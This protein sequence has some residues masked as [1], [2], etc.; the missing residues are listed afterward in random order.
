MQPLQ[1]CI[2]RTIC[3]GQEILDYLILSF[4]FSFL[5]FNTHYIRFLILVTNGALS[6]IYKIVLPCTS[7]IFNFGLYNI[8]QYELKGFFHYHILS[9]QVTH[10][11]I[12]H[13]FIVVTL[14][15]HI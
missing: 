8:L 2:D 13:T 14:S 11:H 7:N 5:L 1:I 10:H 4:T 9:S 3:I 6:D 15:E 12:K